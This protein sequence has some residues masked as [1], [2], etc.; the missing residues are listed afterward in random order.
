[1]N[2]VS[3]RRAVG[4]VLACLMVLGLLVGDAVAK[5]RKWKMPKDGGQM[6]IVEEVDAVARTLKTGGKI[7]LVPQNATIED[8]AGNSISLSQIQGTG[9]SSPADV[10]EIWTRKV[11]KNGQPEIIRLRIKPAIGS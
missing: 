1:M 10:V 5:D 4:T 2:F 6:T 3:K 11:G 7:Y 8:A 9:S